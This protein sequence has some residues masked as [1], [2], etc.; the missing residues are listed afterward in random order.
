MKRFVELLEQGLMK[1]GLKAVNLTF[2][3]ARLTFCSYP[4]HLS[5]FALPSHASFPPQRGGV[6][7]TLTQCHRGQKEIEEAAR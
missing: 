1:H 2:Q 3:K 6:E 5:A 7:L 4:R